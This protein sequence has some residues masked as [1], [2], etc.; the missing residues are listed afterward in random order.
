MSDEFITSGEF[1]RWRSD[2]QGFQER[3]DER[4][5]AGFGGLNHRLDD[6]NGRTRKN[7][8]AIIALDSRVENI[9]T[10]GCSQVKAHRNTLDRIASP[11]KWHKDKRVWVG[12]AGGASIV[13]AL[14][15]VARAVRAL[16]TGAS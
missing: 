11:E 8:E 14:Y 4:L 9:R 10:S 7:A 3:L 15:E 13:A 16:V 6:L 2:F 1:S 5:D 12:G